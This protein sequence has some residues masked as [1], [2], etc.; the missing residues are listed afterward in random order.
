MSCMCVY[1][2]CACHMCVCVTRVC[3]VNKWL[4]VSVND[5]SKPLKILCIIYAIKHSIVF[6]VGLC[7][8][9]LCFR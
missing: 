9:Y 4:G 2:L 8:F 6:N 7:L 1:S 5:L 3:N